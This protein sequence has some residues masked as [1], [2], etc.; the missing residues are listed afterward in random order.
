MNKNMMIHIIMPHFQATYVL[1]I[2]IVSG[3]DFFNAIMCLV[4]HT[5]STK[6][7]LISPCLKLKQSFDV[8]ACAALAFRLTHADTLSHSHRMV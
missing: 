3:N 8:L 7:K 6:L 5:C 1:T 2:A 4:S